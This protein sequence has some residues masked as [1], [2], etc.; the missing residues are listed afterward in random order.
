MAVT[1]SSKATSADL[2]EFLQ[3]SLFN[4]SDDSEAGSYDQQ[5]EWFRDEAENLAI[6]LLNSEME[7]RRQAVIRVVDRHLYWLP[8]TG[9]AVTITIQNGM[10]QVSGLV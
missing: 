6:N 2:V 1:K 8:K 3:A 7:A 10:T 4:P 5:Q 9:D